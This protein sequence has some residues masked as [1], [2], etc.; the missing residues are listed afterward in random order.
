MRSSIV[1]IFISSLLLT[2]CGADSDTGTLVS[3]EKQPFVIQVQKLS[4]FSGSTLTE[5]SG[6]IVAS[7]SL[8]LSSKSAGEISK[9]LVREGQYI[10]P[11]ATVALIRDTVNNYDLRL[12]QAE[13]NL[14]QQNA[15]IA[16]TDANMNTSIDAA[17]IALA[18]ARLAYENS[19]S[20]KNIQLLTLSTTNLRT[21]DSY[22]VLYKNYLSDLERQMTQMLYAGDKI[23][24]I[25]T[26]FEYSNDPWEPYL[27]TRI[28]D[29]RSL[30]V[31]G[32]N[33]LYAAR[34]ELRARI[35]KAIYLTAGSAQADL[36]YITDMYDETTSFADDMLF[37][38]QNN[39]IGGGLPQALQDGWVAEWNGFRAQVQASLSGYGAWQAQVL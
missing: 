32:W 19:I 21:I 17:R 26:N 29:A 8:T 15:S 9:I 38:I 31:S 22:N 11:G 20:R 34:G 13:N 3:A 28:G 4:D 24:G 35:N 1:L 2:S 33:K 36:K 18:R 25:T 6:R 14:L 7:S 16:T 30:A 10:K 12:E 5:K 37:M 23:L 39:V 27:G